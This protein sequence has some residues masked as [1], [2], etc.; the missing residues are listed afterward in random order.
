[1]VMRPILIFTMVMLLSVLPRSFA[2]AERDIQALQE[3]CAPFVIHKENG[4][5]IN[6]SLELAISPEASARGLM[7]REVLAPEGGMIF[8]FP[9]PQP[10]SFWMKNTL[11]PLDMLFVAG[12]GTIMHIHENAVPLSLESVSSPYVVSYVVELNGGTAK[13]LGIK[14]GD[15]LTGFNE[16]LIQ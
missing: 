4:D 10:A 1:M 12:D 16:I 11:I 8:V 9:A 6:L 5:M 2:W 13:R 3:T 15:Y 14:R 7:F